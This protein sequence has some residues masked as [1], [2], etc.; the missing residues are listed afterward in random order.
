MSQGEFEYRPFSYEV[1]IEANKTK[2]Y[3]FYHTLREFRETKSIWGN[4]L[5]ML[6]LNN[7]YES[8]FSLD[9]DFKCDMRDFGVYDDSGWLVLRFRL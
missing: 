5:S 9:R 7:K 1:A 2:W 8:S 3:I 4:S 6:G